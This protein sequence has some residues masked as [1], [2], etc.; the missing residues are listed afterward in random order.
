VTKKRSL[1]LPDRSRYK[2]AVK[3]GVPHGFGERTS[4]DGEI[5]QGS[6]IKGKE[7]GYGT[8]FGLKVTP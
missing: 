4:Q 2:G 6:F 8:L 5:Y 7:E 1:T 3:N